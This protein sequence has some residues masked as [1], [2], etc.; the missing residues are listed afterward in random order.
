MT[1]ARPA[2]DPAAGRPRRRPERQHL[3]RSTSSSSCAT[4]TS[5]GS[6]RLKVFNRDGV[7]VYS[8]E[9]SIVGEAHPD[10]PAI[11]A[12]LAGA[13]ERH[14]K[15]DALRRRRA[16]AARSR[17]TCRCGSAA[18]TRPTA[19]SRSTSRTSRW[20]P[21]SPRT[22]AASTCCSALGFVLLYATLFRIVAV[23]SRTLRHQAL[24]DD[25]HRPAQPRA[26]LRADRGRAGGRRALRRAGRAAADRPR[27]LQGG[28]RHARARLT[29]T[30]CSR[31]SP[32]R[33]R[34]GRAPRR[35]AGA[36]RRRR[37]RRAARAACPHR[38]AV[39]ELRRAPAG[40]ARAAVRAQRR[41]RPCSTRAS[42]SRYCPEHGTDVNTLVQRADVAMYDAKRAR[43]GIETY[44]RRA[45]PVLGR[46]SAAARRAARARSA[47]AS[48]S[49]TTS[50]RS[51]SLAAGD[52]RRGAGALAAPACTGCSR[53]P[54]SCRWPSARARSATSRAGCS[55]PR[56][57]RRARGATP[58]WT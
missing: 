8:D 21:R 54:S 12:A 9:R 46:A 34:D 17:S 6:A 22:P 19:S 43:T 40:R 10:A 55:T 32:S 58:A 35:H 18:T 3:A 33:L 15:D 50:R 23:A 45:R 31:R 26:A 53:P 56:S 16:A 20:R 28:Q 39:A 42:A 41:R 25:A 1:S 11:Q 27:P 7:I 5:S 48:S 4:S 14:V 37:V 47:P 30:D 51:T 57:R 36:P 49:C 24:H 2:A 38:G 44:S 29:A 13:I 52:R